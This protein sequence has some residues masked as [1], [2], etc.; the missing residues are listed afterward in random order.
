MCRRAKASKWTVSDRDARLV[1][2]Q[3]VSLAVQ[4][5]EASGFKLTQARGKHLLSILKAVLQT[6]RKGAKIRAED[7]KRNPLFMQTLRACLKAGIVTCENPWAWR[8]TERN[9]PKPLRYLPS[10]E[11]LWANIGSDRVS[12][13]SDYRL[14]I[15]TPSKAEIEYKPN[16]AVRPVPGAVVEQLKKGTGFCFDFEQLEQDSKGLNRYEQQ[17]IVRAACASVG[18][19]S[20]EIR[21]RVWRQNRVGTLVARQPALLATR[22]DLQGYLKP[23]EG[24]LIVAKID[25]KSSHPYLHLAVCG[26]QVPADVT[27]IYEY[28]CGSEDR[29]VKNAYRALLNNRTERD[30][31]WLVNQGEISREQYTQE[32]QTRRV[33]KAFLSRFPALAKAIEKDTT[34]LHQREAELQG[35][36]LEW[37]VN[38][39]PIQGFIP[40]VDGVLVAVESEHQANQVK[41]LFEQR[42]VMDYGT[43]L[44]CELTLF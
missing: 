23:Q 24:G 16:P 3:A 22:R 14:N 27:S 12:T 2:R 25:R 30:L 20:G 31:V 21:P 9:K 17:E 35:K 26:Y 28:V 44:P 36:S 7:Y 38:A 18:R 10:P 13:Y 11:L 6:T 4:Q 32:L 29:G 41:S 8:K 19:A 37:V 43:T 33:I 15:I 40:W 42:S 39:V 5:L 1:S 34:W